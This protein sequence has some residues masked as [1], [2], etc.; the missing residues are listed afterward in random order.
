MTR[1]TSD[2]SGIRAL[3]GADPRAL[4]DPYTIYRGIR[5]DSGVVEVDDIV[6][7]TGYDAV[8][9]TLRDNTNLS[10]RGLVEG[11]WI[12]AARE[13]L[14]GD[15]LEAFDEVIAFQANFAS[16]TDSAD[17]RRIRTVASKLFTPRN[18]ARLDDSARRYSAEL[19][20][21]LLAS[22]QPDGMVLAARLPLLMM[23]D[24]LGVHRAEL[25]AIQEWSAALGAAVSSYDGPTML[26][27]RFAQQSF[28][29]YVDH[30]IER[31]GEDPE[32][33]ELVRVLMTAHASGHLKRP[34]LAAMFVQL[35]FAGHETTM[36]LLGGG[37]LELLRRPDQWRLLIDDPT[38]I[39]NAVEEL[40]RFITPSQFAARVTVED[41]AVAGVTCPRG[42]TV[43]ASM[44]GANRDPASF[45]DPERLDVCRADARDHL[46]FGAGPHFC[47]GASL[48]RL[49]A[50]AMLDELVRRAPDLTLLDSD[51]SW[52]GGPQLRKLVSLPLRVGRENRRAG[53]L[54]S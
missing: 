25:D 36:T 18:I 49:E 27:A 52:T 8:R 42:Q 41:T 16:R 48:A 45:T 3:L 54:S 10:S 39:P 46:S 37:L 12:A 17:H 1:G 11:S 24:F 20:T 7:V 34:E 51:P 33:T 5:E 19:V 9:A 44:A 53:A 15:A 31:S 30:L 2:L 47:L 35:L 50:A 4:A 26:A 14:D 6:L 29:D 43:L 32:P 13:R 38:R 28:V 40:L 23:G 21:E 22:D